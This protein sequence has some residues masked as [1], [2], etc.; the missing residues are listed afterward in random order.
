MREFYH[1]VNGSQ[2][3]LAFFI[4]TDIIAGMAKP[5]WLTAGDAAERIG[6]SVGTISRK[7]RLGKLRSKAIE[8][9]GKHP[10]VRGVL[11]TDV[12]KIVIEE[13]GRRVAK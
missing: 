1:G 6:C 10:V 2:A 4:A 13:R 9:D 5:R 8:R 12:D 3:A 11:E 7:I